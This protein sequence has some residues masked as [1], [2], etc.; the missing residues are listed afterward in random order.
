MANNCV[1][2]L[3]QILLPFVKYTKTYNDFTTILQC[4]CIEKSY[5]V[6]GIIVWEKILQW[7]ASKSVQNYLFREYVCV[8]PKDS[9]DI[10]IQYMNFCWRYRGDI[11]HTK[12]DSWV[13]I[14]YSALHLILGFSESNINCYRPVGLF[15]L[16]HGECGGKK[17]IILIAFDLHVI[18][19]K[20]IFTCLLL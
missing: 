7:I 17:K 9:I 6:S 1:A 19:I 2:H 14:K 20:M 15:V 5:I 3:S 13:P 11:T 16:C 18:F 8:F 12:S 4:L 10:W